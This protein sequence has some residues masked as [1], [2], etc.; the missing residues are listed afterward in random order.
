MQRR[1]ELLSRRLICPVMMGLA[2]IGP[3]VGAFGKQ[4]SNSDLASGTIARGAGTTIIEGGTGSAGGFVPVL[5]TIAF[6]AETSGGTVTGDF[7]CLARAPAAATGAVSGQFT[8]NAMY[9]TGEITRAVG[10]GDTGTLTGTS[11]ITGLDA[12][13][14]V[15]F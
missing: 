12:P 15:P 11:H 9:V 14:D 10:N 1:I 4:N 5:T 3:A 8:V 13:R 6:H 2:L 7:E